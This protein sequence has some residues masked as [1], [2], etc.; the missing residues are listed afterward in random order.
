MTEM[1]GFRRFRL[2]T[3]QERTLYS[4]PSRYGVSR[5]TSPLISLT[6]LADL[7]LSAQLSA[8][9]FQ[10]ATLSSQLSTLNSQ[11]SVCSLQLAVPSLLLSSL[12]YPRKSCISESLDNRYIVSEYLVSNLDESRRPAK[13]RKFTV[14]LQLSFVLDVT[15]SHICIHVSITG[16]WHASPQIIFRSFSFY[17]TF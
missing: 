10:L 16:L 13:S 2:K 1:M 8:L 7:Q 14:F 9:S 17:P 5:K 6:D 4:S 3:K 15:R 12:I 11:L